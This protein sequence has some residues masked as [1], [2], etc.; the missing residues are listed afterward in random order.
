MVVRA[1]AGSGIVTSVRTDNLFLKL[2]EEEEDLH[3]YLLLDC[4]GSMDFGRPYK[5][6]YARRLAAAIGYLG[7]AVFLVNSL[8]ALGYY[9]PLIGT[10]FAKPP[11]PTGR[12]AVSTW[13]VLPV[14]ALAALTVALG[15]VPGP[16]LD[17]AE[18]AGAYLIGLSA[19][20]AAGTG[21]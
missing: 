12:V 2:F 19:R 8:L 17:W 5:F 7:L 6:H 18:G 10:L 11:A 21:G 14:V 9:L 4:S 13:M 15:L 20:L 1:A 16:W 3:L